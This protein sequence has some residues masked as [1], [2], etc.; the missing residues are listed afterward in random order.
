MLKTF[1]KGAIA[2]LTLTALTAGG[3]MA[4]DN[5]FT[6]TKAA[7]N[8]ITASVKAFKKGDF[9]RSAKFSEAA[10]NNKISKRRQAIAQ[11]NLC[12]ALGEMGEFEKAGEACDTALELRPGYAPATANKNALTVRLA[13]LK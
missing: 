6:V 12:A 5:T 9:D 13:A 7:D 8:Y 3:A 2:A 10:I 1:T 11:S 4:A